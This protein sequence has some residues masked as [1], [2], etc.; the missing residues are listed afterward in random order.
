MNKPNPLGGVVY[1]A[2]CQID[3]R[4]YIGQTTNLLRRIEDHLRCAQRKD[5]LHFFHDAIMEF[6]F[7]N[8]VWDV[9]GEG[10]RKQ[11]LDLEYWYILELD[12]Y[13]PNGYNDPYSWFYY[14][15]AEK[16]RLIEIEYDVY[17]SRQPPR[18]IL[19]SVLISARRLIEQNGFLT[20]D[21]VARR[22]HHQPHEVDR[23]WFAV[24][25]ILNLTMNKSR[26]K[27]SLPEY[28]KQ[29]IRKPS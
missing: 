13:Y 2:T 24:M 23:H 5:C 27:D 7:E 4:I 14:S 29:W 8:F 21:M 3:N 12:T 1:R 9:I 17:F 26:W 11:L 25:K 16:M 28:D 22:N 10:R 15:K 18:P 20:I 19:P 6:G